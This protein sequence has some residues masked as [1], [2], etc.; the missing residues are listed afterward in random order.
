MCIFSGTS[1]SIC[2]SF[3]VYTPRLL[4][5]LVRTHQSACYLASSAGLWLKHRCVVWV[6][7][8]TCPV[9]FM[10]P[11]RLLGS[12]YSG[13]LFCDSLSCAHHFNVKEYLFQMLQAL[14]M[15]H[16]ADTH[17]HRTQS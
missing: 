3:V 7:L 6:L 10:T 12:R 8:L 16:H 14:C 5:V 2:M 4:T 15:L 11:A 17:K 9:P 13:V 1:S